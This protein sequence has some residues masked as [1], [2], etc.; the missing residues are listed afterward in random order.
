MNNSA[1]IYLFNPT[2]SNGLNSADIVLVRPIIMII[3]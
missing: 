1:D 3:G 2:I